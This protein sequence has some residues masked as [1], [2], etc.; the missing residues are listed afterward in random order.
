MIFDLTEMFS[1]AQAVTATGASTNIIDTGATGTAYGAAAAMRR[2]LG[3][4]TTIPLAIRVVESFNNLTSIIITYE[5][6]DDAAFS[7]NKTTVFTSP[8]YL[9]ADLATG[10]RHLLPDAIPVTADRRYH[11]LLY[12]LA[13]TTPTLGKIT[14]GIVAGNQ[15]NSIL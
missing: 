2:D 5:V 6:A 7:T 12:T 3:K 4:G 9:L 10:A 8:T 15:T 11:R 13:G 1:N 14:A